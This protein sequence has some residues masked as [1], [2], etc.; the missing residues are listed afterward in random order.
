[1]LS[2][3]CHRSIMEKELIA[4]RTIFAV[5]QHSREFEMRLTIGKPYPSSHGDWACP[6]SMI[7][8]HGTFPDMYGI[9]SWQ[10]LMNVRNLL[11][12]LL[13]YF[14]EDGGKLYWEKGGEEL[15]IEELFGHWQED[16]VPDGPLTTDELRRV[17]SLTAEE[18]QRIDDA[19][20]SHA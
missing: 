1:M 2:E 13:R 6:V 10:A 3:L 18:L 9:D 17:E 4:E 16:R 11:H 7:G 12:D 19:I 15:K 8:L 5:D 14:V 20:M